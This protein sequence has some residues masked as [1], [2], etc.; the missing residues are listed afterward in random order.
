MMGIFKNTITTKLTITNNHMDD[1][2]LE[3]SYTLTGG[4]SVSGIISDTS[5]K[6]S[7]TLNAGAS[8]TITLKSPEG[9]STNTL[10]ITGLQLLSDEKV[11]ATFMPATNGSYTV[12]GTA[13]TAETTLEKAGTESYALVATPASGYKFF[14]WWSGST[15]SYMSYKA[16]DSIAFIAD[17]QL[18]PRFIPEDWAIFSVGGTR[19]YDLTEA[20]T[21][22]S[23]ATSK[24][25]VTISNGVIYGAHTIPAGVTLLV[26]FDDVNTLYTSEPGCTSYSSLINASGNIAWVQ[27]KEYRTLTLDSTANITVN[28]S[29]SLSAKH[30][31]ANGGKDFCGAPTDFCSFMVMESGS[32]ITLNSGANFYAWGFITGSGT[33]D[34]LDG[35]K[36]YEFFQFAD[37]RGGTAT[38]DMANGKTTFP[39]S[40]YFVQNI[41]VPITFYQGSTETLTTSVYMQK[42]CTGGSVVFI[43][44]GG[45]FIPDEGGYV[46]KTYDGS[47]DR[48]VFDVYEN[49]TINS[50]SMT[51]ASTTV[52]SAD[53]L[54]P[55]NGNIDIRVHSG[56]CNLSQSISM[57]PG[58]SALTEDRRPW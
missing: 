42:N 56:E 2:T 16:T 30:A 23:T 11:S 33:I 37:F 40:Q 17:P 28:G 21:Y 48:L 34:A 54:L 49:A 7:A 46:T 12:D 38:T 31:A 41:E 22:A 51:L 55:I 10:T 57:L 39:M 14:G 6:Y 20:G 50:I 24:T 29:I 19:F 1:R 9:T 43:G 5:G 4:G 13:I 53:Y 45:L 44:T 35:S 36:V 8:V 3:F 15:S 58:R 26:P 27:P 32:K 18:E 47:R 52:N 25:I